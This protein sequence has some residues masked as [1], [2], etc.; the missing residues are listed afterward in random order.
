MLWYRL[1]MKKGDF[2]AANDHLNKA[3]AVSAEP[4]KSD[5]GLLFDKS[6]LM[7][8][9]GDYDTAKKDLEQIIAKEPNGLTARLRLARL[10]ESQ[11]HDY[12]GALEQYNEALRIDPL[13]AAAI[14]GKERCQTK[15]RNIALQLKMSLREAWKKFCE[16]NAAPSDARH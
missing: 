5:D 15:G 10:L 4:G 16:S 8:T 9:I 3:I 6:D 12:Q 7:Q 2:A 14:A 1:A 13:S 11:F